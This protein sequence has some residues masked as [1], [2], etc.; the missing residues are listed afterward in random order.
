MKLKNYN[1]FKVICFAVIFLS[2]CTSIKKIGTVNMISNRNIEHS[3]NYKLLSSYSGGSDNE[4]KKSRSKSIEEAIDKTVKKVVG[5][6]YL[7]NVNM[8]VIKG[9]Y[10]AV[11]GDVWGAAAEL[12]YRGFKVGDK[13]T[14]KNKSLAAT[15]SGKKNYITG[16]IKAFKDDKTCLI[17]IEGEEKTIEM[18]YDDITKAQ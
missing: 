16:T 4:L 1:I 18:K 2:A 11:E 5:G 6:E 17:E 15:F 14:W 3:L 10:Y 7:M 13:V 9:K 12:S 8:Y